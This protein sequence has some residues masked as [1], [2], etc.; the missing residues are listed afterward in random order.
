LLTKSIA[1]SLHVL[2]DGGLKYAASLLAHLTG[3]LASVV[4]RT[5]LIQYVLGFR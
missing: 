4:A 1:N 3:W 5:P 2:P